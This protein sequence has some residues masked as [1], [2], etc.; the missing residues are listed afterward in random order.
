[1]PINT[2]EARDDIVVREVSTPP[3]DV[4]QDSRSDSVLDRVHPDTLSLVNRE[5]SAS[6]S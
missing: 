3:E 1:M 6:E 5:E 4:L 2:S